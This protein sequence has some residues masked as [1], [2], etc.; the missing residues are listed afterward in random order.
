M[1]VREFILTV[2]IFNF[3]LFVVYPAVLASVFRRT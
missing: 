3:L 2:N 1:E